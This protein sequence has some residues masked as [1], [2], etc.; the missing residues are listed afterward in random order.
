MKNRTVLIILAVLIA[1]GA[2]IFL[3]ERD[4]MT[5]GER[6]ERDDRLFQKYQRD[7]VTRLSVQR[8]TGETV[9]LEKAKAEAGD[10]GSW[11]I[12]E[13]SP[14]AAEDSEVRAMLSSID[15]VLAGRSV[16]RTDAEDKEGFGLEKP[17]LA[18][19]F[20][21]RGARTSFRIGAQ[22]PGERVYLS[23]DGDGAVVHAV[24]EDIFE[25]LD[26]GVAQ[27][28]SKRLSPERLGEAVAIAVHGTSGDYSVSRPAAL[29][30]WALDT[31][32]GKV[33]ASANAAGELLTQLDGLR[34]ESFIADEVTPGKL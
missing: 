7:E 2:F 29:D 3:V 6:K 13:P 27:L 16:D 1:L 14:R 11:R 28:R 19:S 21:I 33:L 31:K 4:S 9:V 22:A 25:S 34:A 20:D 5:T 32:V 18:V 10:E 12:V 8:A 15:F 26:K 23:I 17:R 24:A 30:A